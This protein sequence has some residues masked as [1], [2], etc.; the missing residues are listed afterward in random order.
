MGGFLEGMNRR[1]GEVRAEETR[2]ADRE[3][4]GLLHILETAAQSENLD[5]TAL[6][7]LVSMMLEA[8][9]ASKPE[10]K[11]I[12]PLV[13]ALFTQGFGAPETMTAQVP[14]VSLPPLET[15]GGGPAFDPPPMAPATAEVTTGRTVKKPLMLSRDEV[16]RRRLAD[17][18]A[19]SDVDFGDFER[20]QKVIDERD[21]RNDE[22]TLERERLK[23]QERRR[24]A[25]EKFQRALQKMEAQ[26]RLVYTRERKKL[27]DSYFNSPGFTG[28]MA[29][30]MA[31]ASEQMVANYEA[32][33]GVKESRIA[34]NEATVPLLRARVAQTIASTEKTINEMVSG[35]TSAA[36]RTFDLDT[37][38]AFGQWRSIQ[39]ER[40]GIHRRLA[41]SK[42]L[43]GDG[44]AR[45]DE[46]DKEE[47][48]VKAQIDAARS[49]A[50]AAG[51]SRRSGGAA[52]PPVPGAAPAPKGR[53]SRRNFD[54]V[55]AKNPSLQGKSDAEVEAA[56][57]ARG[58]VVY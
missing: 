26:D 10:L 18:Q 57:K 53:V 47:E 5:P 23:T 43:P 27:A 30:A 20:R 8:H 44:Q 54:R 6:P 48:V 36:K 51:I 37:K 24:E 28:T 31:K 40:A 22:R 58:V 41:E 2:D 32:G 45:L 7:T 33:V 21:V 29:D 39:Q 46:L 34:V 17:R 56:L 50:R 16:T 9:G 42:M 14:Q 13:G 38:D 11:R 15:G 12:K 35:I 3:R 55:R 4:A 19:A 52:P 25:D 49:R 1:R